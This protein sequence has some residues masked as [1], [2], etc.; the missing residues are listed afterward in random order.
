MPQVAGSIRKTLTMYICCS[1]DSV[2][3]QISNREKQP[4]FCDVFGDKFGEEQ[5]DLTVKILLGIT[6]SAS[7]S[8]HELTFSVP[9]DV[10]WLTKLCPTEKKLLMIYLHEAVLPSQR[11][12]S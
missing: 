8:R 4:H 9:G 7:A 5:N 11:Y 3:K 10:F 1:G 2:C 12:N 6:Y